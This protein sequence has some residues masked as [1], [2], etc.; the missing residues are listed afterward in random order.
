MTKNT[1]SELMNRNMARRGLLIGISE[2]LLRLRILPVGMIRMHQVV[3]RTATAHRRHA[4]EVVGRR[5]RGRGPFQRPGLPW[6]V[7]CH[8]AALEA[9]IHIDHEDKDSEAQDERSHR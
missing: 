8:P 2:S 6:I 7:A 3:E 9:Y 1:P 4:V 5:R